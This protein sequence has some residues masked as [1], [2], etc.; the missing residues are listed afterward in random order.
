MEY[1]TLWHMDTWKEKKKK[2]NNHLGFHIPVLVTAG[3][4]L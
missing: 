3:W 1:P 2:Q 4:A